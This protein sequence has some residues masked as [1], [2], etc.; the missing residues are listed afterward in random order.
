[1]GQALVRSTPREVSKV[2]GKSMLILELQRTRDRSS[3]EDLGEP[4]LSFDE[5][6]LHV[7]FHKAPI[8]TKPF[9][10]GLTGVFNT[11]LSSFCLWMLVA[12]LRI[13]RKKEKNEERLHMP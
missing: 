12:T 11:G 9:H 13:K 2:L 5:H 7:D 3:L 10:R 8:P 6:F 4:V 1:M